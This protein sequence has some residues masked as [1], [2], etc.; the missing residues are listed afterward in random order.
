[1][2][3]TPSVSHNGPGPKEP[4]LIPR[5]TLKGEPPPLGWNV[6]IDGQP[7]SPRGPIQTPGLPMPVPGPIPSAW[8]APGT[9]GLSHGDT[10]AK[11]TSNKEALNLLLTRMAKDLHVSGL[12]NT[13]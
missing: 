4:H 13:S 3:E 9:D 1:M 8:E 7:V 2:P 11:G 6:M 5:K 12:T 10:P